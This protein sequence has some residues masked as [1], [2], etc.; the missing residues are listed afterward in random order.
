MFAGSYKGNPAYN[1]V[2]LYDQDGN[3]VGKISEG[4]LQAQQ[5]ILAHVP[6]DIEEPVRRVADG[7]WI[8]WV[9]PDTD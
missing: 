1:V 9:A 7:T 5:I 3:I 6:E 8:Y 4:E 2:L